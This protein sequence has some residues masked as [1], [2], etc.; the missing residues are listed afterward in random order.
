MFSFLGSLKNS[1]REHGFLKVLLCGAAGQPTNTG[2]VMVDLAPQGLK[3]LHTANTVP[4][5]EWLTQVLRD[6]GFAMEHVP[7]AST[8]IFGTSG[9]SSLYVRPDEHDEA[10]EFLHNYLG[11]ET[12]TND[13]SS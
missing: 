8:G 10:A 1:L 3:L 9:N 7:T 5:A 2:R 4:E 11:G 12:L 6:A 13:S